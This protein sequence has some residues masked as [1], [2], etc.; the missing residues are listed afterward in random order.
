[1]T[2]RPKAR[3]ALRT[4]LTG[5]VA[6]A[7]L[8]LGAVPAVAEEPAAGTATISGMVTSEFDGTPIDGVYVEATNED[9][10]SW[11]GANTDASGSYTL[12]GLL[13]GDYLVQFRSPGGD[14]LGEHWKDSTDWRSAERVALGD[15]EQRSGIDAA[16]TVGGSISGTVTR[17][18]DGSPVAGVSVSANGVN[19]GWGSATTA[20]DGTYTIH[21]L[22]AD[23]Y[24]VEFFP[25]GTDLM[26]EYWDD[27]MTWDIATAVPVV[28]AQS[29]TGI[30]AALAVGGAITGT[31]SR[32]T[33]GSPV[34]Y[35]SVSALTVNGE[36]AGSAM[37]DENGVYRIDG[38]APGAYVVRFGAD[39]PLVSEYWSDARS[40]AAAAAVDVVAGATVE[41]IDGSLATASYISGTVT[42]AADG[43][44]L[45]GVVYITEPD[46]G[47]E[48]VTA[49]IQPDGTYRAEVAPGEHLVQFHAYEDGILDEYW[50]NARTAAEATRV[51]V[52]SGEEL[53]GIDAQLEA[54]ARI[55]GVV[56][57]D[58]SEDGEL[59]VEA[60]DGGQLVHSVLTSI[61]DGAYTLSLPA[62]TYTLKARAVFY[63]GSGT[64]VKPQY[65]NGATTAKK[66]TPVT[67]ASGETVTGIDFTLV[68]KAKKVK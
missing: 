5:A 4:L 63:N 62:G 27:A 28:A 7:A 40:A 65:Y 37:T 67:V 33:D 68:P 21:A 36:V 48:M 3:T 47:V 14:F 43:A 12:E 25:E 1:M 46:G 23:E 29:S 56:R 17:E 11:A 58:S 10:S 30:D 16:L 59:I 49:D 45:F 18:S 66:A 22:R 35:A 50:Q 2:A 61:Q 39:S 53:T 57:I 52:A 42:K 20:D 34:A 55:T 15:G 31:V 9:G 60:Y 44:P 24:V 32:D 41:S 8:L 13:A 38:L 6:L 26:R 64:T 19:G 54:A 51:T